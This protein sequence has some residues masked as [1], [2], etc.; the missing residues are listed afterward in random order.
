[1]GRKNSKIKS[2]SQDNYYF[3]KGMLNTMLNPVCYKDRNGIYLGV[4]EIYARQIVG[5]PEEKIVGHKLLEVGRKIAER[6]PER[7]V[8][9]GISLLEHVK[10][11]EKDD[12]K[13]LRHGGTSTHEYEGICADGIKRLF[14]VNKSTFS[15]ENGEILGLFTVLQDITERDEIQ[16]KL[17]EKEERYRFITEQ[18]E[19]LVYDFDFRSNKGNLEGAIEEVTGYL[20]KEFQDIPL[21][22][23]IEYIHPEDRERINEKVIIIQNEGGKYRQEFRFRKKDGTYFYAEDRGVCLLDKDGKPH[24]L[25]GVIKDI[26]ERE[27]AHERVQ[28]SEERY[29]S[30]IENFKGIV[31]QADEFF[32]PQFLHGAVEEI[33]GHS[34]E[35]FMSGLPWKDIIDPEDLSAIVEEEKRIREVPDAYTIEREFRIRNRKRNTKWL[36][37]TCQKIPGKDG[38]PEVYQGVIYDVTKRRQAEET[39]AG[40][41]IARKKEIHH[42]IKNNLQVISSLLDLQAEK[43][44][45]TKCV[46]DSE[47]LEAFRES[48]DRVISIALIHE[49]LHEGDGTDNTLNFSPYLERLIENLFQAYT[50]GDVDISLHTDLE[51]NI[52]L[53]MDTAVPLG[54]IVNELISNSLK[55][56]FPGKETGEI[57][58]K[59]Y[60]EENTENEQGNCSKDRVGNSKIA[61]FILTVS[62]DGAGIP[63]KVDIDNSDTLGLQL[64]S[65]LVDQLEGE[66]ELNR[67]KGTEF[68]IKISVAAKL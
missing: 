51:E 15:N 40:I 8:V 43:F 54:L 12:T 66:M 32:I 18:T 36:H 63:E 61:R 1:M 23:W 56:A 31:F 6:F 30:F 46:K 55:H 5:L 34:E 42:R 2:V 62:D 14:L 19:Q 57:R 33:T 65:M 52:I 26:T 49:E 45:N 7:S 28:K 21:D 39:L 13:L 37:E 44:K 25:L 10:G 53:N 67:D 60:R 47:V 22:V 41:E 64:V 20:P 68:T 48:Q 38:K 3:I 35:E 50:L 4:N 9:N 29:R 27:L 24:K 59:L 16:R 17:Q 58:I 11:W